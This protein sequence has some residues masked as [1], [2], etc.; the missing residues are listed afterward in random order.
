LAYP[1]QWIGFMPS[2]FVTCPES[3]HLEEID[4]IATPIGLLVKRCS[5]F[6]D[7]IP[8]CPRSCTARLDQKAQRR[9]RLADGSVLIATSVLRDGRASRP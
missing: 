4:V 6:A 2:R 5:A 7:G 3:A 9:R 8:N 1:L